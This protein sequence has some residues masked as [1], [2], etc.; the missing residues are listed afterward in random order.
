MRE[1]TEQGAETLTIRDDVGDHEGLWVPR[2]GTL[3]C[4]FLAFLADSPRPSIFITR[5]RSGRG[6]AFTLEADADP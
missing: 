5:D 6:E 4:S 2:S 3:P 1:S